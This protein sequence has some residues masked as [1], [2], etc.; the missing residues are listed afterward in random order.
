MLR[1]ALLMSSRA[2][3]L[4]WPAYRVVTHWASAVP[5]PAARTPATSAILRIERTERDVIRVLSEVHWG[6]ARPAARRRDSCGP[7]PAGERA[8]PPARL[9][10]K[11]ATTRL[12]PPLPEGGTSRSTH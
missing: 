6:P 11:T 12:L 8:A 1:P 2:A 5:A 10:T 4:V 7:R 3:T 9:T